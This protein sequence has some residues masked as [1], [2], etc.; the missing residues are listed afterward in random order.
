MNGARD[1]PL[2]Q[3]QSYRKHHEEVVAPSEKK[4]KGIQ[5]SG[6]TPDRELQQ[7]SFIRAQK[8]YSVTLVQERKI[9]K[10]EGTAT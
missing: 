5:G 3:V 1:K 4:K 6:I 9:T 7:Q 8:L 10:E 2:Q